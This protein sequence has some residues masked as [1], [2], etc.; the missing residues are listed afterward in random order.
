M[1]S[2]NIQEVLRDDGLALKIKIYHRCDDDMRLRS[3][4]QA[5]LMQESLGGLNSF[6]QAKETAVASSHYMA[7]HSRCITVK[8]MTLLYPPSSTSQCSLKGLTMNG[9]WR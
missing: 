2:K 6:P 1:S 3:K 9:V 5:S 4:A 8:V 7:E